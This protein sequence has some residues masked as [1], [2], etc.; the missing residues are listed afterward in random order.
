M[1]LTS[2]DII[3]Q[4]F[5]RALRGFEQHEVR[6]FLEVVADAY[7]ELANENKLLSEQVRQREHELTA[8]SQTLGARDQ[9]LAQCQAEMQKLQRSL[10]TRDDADS[11]LQKAELEAGRLISDAH[12]KNEQARQELRLLQEMKSKVAAHLREYLRSQMALLDIIGEEEH[13]TTSA[14]PIPNAS[15][16][17]AIQDSIETPASG[18][19]VE[20]AM[21]LGALQ[22]G[23]QR[24]LSE[25][26]MD[27]LPPDLVEEISVDLAFGTSPQDEKMTEEEKRRKILNDLENL[28]QHATAMFKKADFHKMLG[29]D[30]EKK[31]EDIINRIYAELEKRK[32][33]SPPEVS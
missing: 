31:S 29:E 24:F 16:T 26:K 33:Q 1:K 17:P 7:D 4:E 28:S 10:E 2:A 6:A 8:L 32:N 22:S 14:P 20:P 19:T 23:I 12:Q 11:L 13:G 15:V 3:H 9:A 25:V 21:D 5:K 18:E 27:D 30:A